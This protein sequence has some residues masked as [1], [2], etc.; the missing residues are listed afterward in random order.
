MPDPEHGAPGTQQ[1]SWVG[2]K[3][4]DTYALRVA[5]PSVTDFLNMASEFL[6]FDN[7]LISSATPLP[8]GKSYELTLVLPVVEVELV[9][10]ARMSQPRPGGAVLEIVSWEEGHDSALWTWV[11]L[12]WE[13]LRAAGARRF[14][15]PPPA[16]A[17]RPDPTAWSAFLLQSGGA[18]T[19]HGRLVEG[20][21]ARSQQDPPGTG[22]GIS[23]EKSAAVPVRPGGPP[24]GKPT[25]PIVPPRVVPKRPR[26]PVGARSVDSGATTFV[27]PPS[28]HSMTVS[29]TV[30]PLPFV[31]DDIRIQAKTGWLEVTGGR[32]SRRIRLLDGAVVQIEQRP[33]L[34]VDFLVTAVRAVGL[35]W[36]LVASHASRL[37]YTDAPEEVLVSLGAF[38]QDQA[39]RILSRRISVQ[40]ARVIDESVSGEAG[41]VEEKRR[42]GQGVLLPDPPVPLVR[43]IWDGSRSATYRRPRA[44]ANVLRERLVRACLRWIG[45]DDYPLEEATHRVEELDIILRCKEDIASVMSYLSADGKDDRTAL[46]TVWSLL[47]LGFLE[48]MEPVDSLVGD[49]SETKKAAP[50]RR[51]ARSSTPVPSAG[52]GQGHETFTHVSGSVTAATPAPPPCMPARPGPVLPPTGSTTGASE[53][54]ARAGR[55][56]VGA[57]P[58]GESAASSPAADDAEAERVQSRVGARSTPAPSPS[59]ASK[60]ASRAERFT[61]SPDKAESAAPR[62]PAEGS[63]RLRTLD[64]TRDRL[65]QLDH[66]QALGLPWSAHPDDIQSAYVRL[67]DQY[68]GA[69]EDEDARIVE[70][71]QAIIRRLVQAFEVLSDDA[72][73][74][75]YRELLVGDQLRAE[76]ERLM[77]QGGLH[78]LLDEHEDALRCFER[79]ADLAPERKDVRK[80]LERQRLSMG[81][82]LE[83]G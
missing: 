80:E 37:Q 34:P 62:E 4:T 44:V 66:F 58:P 13:I 50:R 22:G 33:H 57:T 14:Q 74:R 12:A 64:E 70:V 1:W 29:L 55:G 77:K 19:D 51:G 5:Y 43:M 60:T 54:V 27:S 38:N 6:A 81:K 75:S 16:R 15:A 79:A 72:R 67:L 63:E 11:A 36:H 46:A 35:D 30:R 25:G 69:T 23:L 42:P 53:G 20:P 49:G 61:A 45:R 78:Y 47:Q 26:R 10:R 31:L 65:E 40:L 8:P 2:C 52:D 32:A 82:T 56:V 68:R 76:V 83:G 17:I 9:C 18:I 7:I 28:R 48:A 59:I 41:F 73:R 21:E 39:E 3:M 71:T 24:S